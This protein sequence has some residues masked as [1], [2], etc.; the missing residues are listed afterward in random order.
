LFGN[1][2]LGLTPLTAP[3]SPKIEVLFESLYMKGAALS[4]LSQAG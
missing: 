4:G 1:I 2:Q 3:S